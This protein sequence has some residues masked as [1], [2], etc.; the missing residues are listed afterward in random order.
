LFRKLQT[1]SLIATFSIL[2]IF[3]GGCSSSGEEPTDD[4]DVNVSFNINE[5]KI[6]ELLGADDGYSFSIFYGAD[7]DGSLETCG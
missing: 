3:L 2:L 7:I 5:P 6:K 4:G 1:H